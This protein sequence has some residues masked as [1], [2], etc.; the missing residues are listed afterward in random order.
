MTRAA[1]QLEQ[2][3]ASVSSTVSRIERAI[4]VRIFERTT[5]SIHITNEG[6]AVIDGCRD[7]L[8]RWRR[9]LEEIQGE[10]D[11]ITGTVNLS[12]P[13]DT[14]Y[15][16]LAPVIA[17]V[18][19]EHPRLRL[20]VHSS[21]IVQPIRRNAIDMAIRYGSMKDSSLMARKL[22]QC[23]SVLVAAPSYLEKHGPPKTPKDLK[24]HKLLTLQLSDYP[25]KSW[26]LQ[27]NDKSELVT[28][29]SSLCGDGY[30]A[31]QWAISGQGIAR[32]SLFDVI[33]DLEGG[34]LL[35]V[36]PDY[37][38]GAIAIHAVFPSHQYL[39]SRVRVVDQAIAAAFKT[40]VKRCEAWQKS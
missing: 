4:D 30:L 40:Q 32:K 9:T 16:P 3:P 8:H 31:R 29:E 7:V 21:D 33:D 24:K 23:Q 10:D 26:T 22:A 27:R 14:T 34:R 25:E 5:R 13:A 12:A 1:A 19:L 15:G 37:T 2:T 36:L 20:I 11:E 38:C 39:P 17:S 28:I 6:L 35:H 18:A